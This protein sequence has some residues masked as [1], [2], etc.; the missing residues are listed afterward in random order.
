META[1]ARLEAMFQKAEA[2]LDWIQHRL[3]YEI[4]KIFPDDTPPEENPLAIL[5]GLSAAK[6]RY[7]ALCTRMDGIAR[8][9][10]EAMRGIQASVENT[11]KTVQELQQKAG[12]ESLPLSAE[13]Q[14]AAQQ[15]GSQTGTEIE[16]SVG[17]PG[18]AGSTVP[19]SA[20]ASQFQPL[21]EEMLLTVPWHIRRSVTLADLNSLYRGLF[22][23]FVVNKNKA[24][25]SISQ[26]DEMSTKPSHSR[27]QVLEELG[28][29]KSSKKGDIELVV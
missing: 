26:V 12:L 7:Q 25:L 14:A 18:C 16:S 22:K 21:T 24:A 17:K 23:H 15:L 13:E 11:M 28:I 5:E 19:G 10:K 20:E 6:A 4:M 27:I 2:D 9:Q 8:E 29:V 3:E 1:V